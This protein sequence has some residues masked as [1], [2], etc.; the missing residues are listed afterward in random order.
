MKL[1]GHVPLR[2][3]SSPSDSNTNISTK[4]KAFLSSSTS[5]F[6]FILVGCFWWV[7]EMM[8]LCPRST[9]TILVD[10]NGSSLRLTDIFSYD[11]GIILVTRFGYCE[12]DLSHI[13]R[14]LI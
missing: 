10:S 1:K 8:E 3:N 12:S 4:E 7:G 14:A 2:G 11:Y 6:D 9:T 13:K 5:R